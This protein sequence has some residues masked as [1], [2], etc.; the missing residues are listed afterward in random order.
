MSS[1]FVILNETISNLTHLIPYSNTHENDVHW[2]NVTPHM[3]SVVKC[4]SSIDI[5]AVN[6]ITHT[7]THTYTYQVQQKHMASNAEN[8]TI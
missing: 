3:D 7:R 5:S 6:G 8:A 4:N 1:V 2:N